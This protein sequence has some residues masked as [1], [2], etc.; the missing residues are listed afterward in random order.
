MLSPSSMGS[1]SS[2]PLL[3]SIAALPSLGAVAAVAPSPLGL[4]NIL[5]KT[6]L[7][8]LSCTCHCKKGGQRGLGDTRGGWGIKMCLHLLFALDKG[9][10]RS[11]CLASWFQRLQLFHICHCLVELTLQWCKRRGV[12]LRISHSAGILHKPGHTETWRNKH[13]NDKRRLLIVPVARPRARGR[14]PT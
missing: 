14:S 13:G 3:S 11:C 9:N 10:L 4:L 7:S 5:E 2:S 6:A 12:G 8:L 1:P